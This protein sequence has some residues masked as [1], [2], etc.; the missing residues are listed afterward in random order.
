MY[1][2]YELEVNIHRRRLGNWSYWRWQHRH[3]QSLLVGNENEG[4]GNVCGNSREPL[5]KSK[6]EGQDKVERRM[7]MTRERAKRNDG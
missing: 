4:C 6:E 3:T 5:V 1:E 2:G 7:M